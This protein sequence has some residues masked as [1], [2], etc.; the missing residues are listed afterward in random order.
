MTD[1]KRLNDFIDAVGLKKSY[2]AKVMGLSV[3]GL[4]MKITNRTDFKSGEIKK[5]SELLGMTTEE[6]D[7]IFFAG[8]V[9]L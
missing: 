5:L 3:K 7:A 6:R 2:I 8:E 4:W 9:D 1:T